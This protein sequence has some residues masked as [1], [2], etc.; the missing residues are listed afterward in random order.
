VRG[1]CYGTADVFRADGEMVASF[2]QDGMIRP[3]DAAR[4]GSVL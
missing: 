1:R 3:L 2:V 4:A